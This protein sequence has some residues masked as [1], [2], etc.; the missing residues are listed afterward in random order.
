MW[1]RLEAT[2][3]RPASSSILVTAP[4]RL[5]RVASGLM[6]EKVRVTAM[7]QLH[8]L[9]G[10][11]I[12]RAPS[13]RA[14]TGKAQPFLTQLAR[15][16][17]PSSC[18]RRRRGRTSS[19]HASRAASSVSVVEQVEG[20]VE[21]QRRLAPLAV[22]DQD[23]AGEVGGVDVPSTAGSAGAASSAAAGN[24]VRQETGR[25]LVPQLTV[26]P[27]EQCLVA[28]RRRAAAGLR[29]S[30]CQRCAAMTLSGRAAPS[31]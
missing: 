29:R 12:G 3:R 24:A 7:G 16:R 9:S 19:F 20:A 31:W 6:I 1:M 18:A 21:A 26:E 2:T 4:V 17:A 22:G 27:R 8:G 11:R 23:V 28:R 5:R 10:L 14:R 15:L 13:G 30:A 25:A